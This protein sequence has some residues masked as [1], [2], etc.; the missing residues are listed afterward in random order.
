MNPPPKND[1]P[2][3]QGLVTEADLPAAEREWPGLR[4]YLFGLPT[5]Q[6]PKTFLDLVWRFESAR[7][8]AA[9]A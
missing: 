1:A 3:L 7:L 2:A 4:A 6:R 9:A 8:T 5:G